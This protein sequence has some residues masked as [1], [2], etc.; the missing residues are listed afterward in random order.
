MGKLTATVIGAGIQG[1]TVALEL[2]RLG[3]SVNLIE[4]ELDIFSRASISQEGKVHTGM[5][6]ALD[7]SQK[8]PHRMIE[9]ALYFAPILEKLTE[10]TIDWSAMQSTAFHYLVD[11]DSLWSADKLEEKYMRFQDIFADVLKKPSLHYLAERPEFYYQ[12]IPMPAVFNP[13]RF[14]ECFISCEK[15][16]DPISIKEILKNNIISKSNIRLWLGHEVRECIRY[17]GGFKTCASRKDYQVV[18]LSS[19]IVINATWERK[20]QIDRMLDVGDAHQWS[21]RLKLGFIGRQT[22]G[23]PLPSFVIVHGP[24]GDFVRFPKSGYDYFSWYPTCRIGLTANI[25]IPQ[26]WEDILKGSYQSIELDTIK[27]TSLLALKRIAPDCT[28]EISKVLAGT[29]VARGEKDIDQKESGLHL[30]SEAPIETY[31][32]YF[33]MNT[34]KFTSAPN[35]ARKLGRMLS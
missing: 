21:V 29:V 30:R 25:E 22:A 9:D 16:I 28:Y 14:Q 19:D 8:T 17:D 32:G 20:Q 2:A 6:Y 12:K 23:P 4:K 26:H 11:R 33:S 10:Q 3:Y 31:D 18:A 27:N 7:P 34:G 35:N 24:F 15:A 5:I 13:E 1:C